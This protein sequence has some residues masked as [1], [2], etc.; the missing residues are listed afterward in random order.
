[1]EKILITA[2]EP[3]KKKKDRF[4]IFVG[5]EYYASLGAEACAIFKIAAGE[6]INEEVLKKAV[7]KDNE[8]YAF[9][10]AVAMLAHSARTRHEIETRLL[11]RNIDSHAVT[12]CT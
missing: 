5:G 2:K 11:A 6:E 12:A 9:D 3:Q 10:S 8:R 4:N 7:A 1:M